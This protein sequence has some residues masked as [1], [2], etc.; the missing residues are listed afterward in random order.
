MK[1]SVAKRVW[2]GFALITALL[3]FGG[4][5]SFSS[6]N[7][8]DNSQQQLTQIAAPILEHSKAL[9]L[10]LAMSR[11]DLLKAYY[12]NTPQ[13]LA[14]E[15]QNFLTQ[16]DKLDQ[17][18]Q[19]LQDKASKAQLFT[20]ELTSIRPLIKQFNDAAEQVLRHR[21]EHVSAAL[22]AQKVVEAQSEVTD[23]AS[24]YLL[25]L[26]DF[27]DESELSAEQ[28]IAPVANDIENNLTSL[29]ATSRDLL[30]MN[31]LKLLEV[32][33]DELDYS[34]GEINSALNQLDLAQAGFSEPE[35]LT[36]AIQGIKETL[37]MLEGE[38]SVFALQRKQIS[39]KA[40]AS[41]RLN[42][43][44]GTSDSLVQ[45]LEQ[46]NVQIAEFS[47]QAR[48]QV[49]QKV[50]SASTVNTVVMILSII[51]TVIIAFVVVRSIVRPL[52]A[53]NE[54]LHV[55]ASG[56]LTRRIKSESQDEFGVLANNVNVL[57]D[58][59][60]DLINGI[61]ER[62]T[63]LGAAAEQTSRVTHQSTESIQLQR[64][65]IEQVAT[66]T[67]EMSSTSKQVERSADETLSAVKHADDEAEHVKALAAETR[68]TMVSLASEV[69][70]ASEVIDQLH[71]DS[72]SIGS[73]L[74]V[75]RGIA[76]QTNLLA[77]NAAIEA[78]RAGEQGRGFAVVA[79]EVRSL[80]SRTQE[81]TQEINNMIEKL[82]VGARQAVT[83][84]AQGQDMAESCVKQVEDSTNALEVITNSVHHAHDISS[85][86]NHAAVEQTE[87]TEQ[88]SEQLEQI[89]TIAEENTE[90][91]RQ[92][93]AASQ[94]V[95]AL[96]DELK[97]SIDQFTV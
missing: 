81:S 57:I 48:L 59:L 76:E 29:L 82:Q 33:A 28:E 68:E 43:L 7:T 63:Q 3:L 9:R 73:I 84:M 42:R 47:N 5:N 92:T 35:L 87:V 56:N 88:I 46:L 12:Q 70:Q 96:S 94:Q 86:I 19:Q 60:R 11:E 74:D 64:Q 78:A 77:L 2:L 37:R 66:A 20:S 52:N 62:S 45:K 15:K 39:E 83:V 51:A 79:D 72:T 49:E 36:D 93:A 38:Q 58:N 17:A 97:S 89:V 65:K 95:A 10:Q 32:A 71:E 13:N 44:A 30:T 4:I 18:F 34:K 69:K 24:S 31:T 90:G 85:Q 80:A 53:V 61:L 27:S 40:Q 8:V 14:S 41:Q 21:E 26:I 23:D 55:V 50:S 25:D 75:I 6:L 22:S 54:I 67:T 1:L 91:A 16:S